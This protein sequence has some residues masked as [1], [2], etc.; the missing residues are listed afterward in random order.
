MGK[1]A[2]SKALFALMLVLLLAL[3][4]CSDESASEEADDNGSDE[5]TEDAEGT[6][7]DE[8]EEEE[9]EVDP[10][11]VVYSIDDFNHTKTNEGEAIDGGTLNF[12]LVSD[13]VFEGTLNW[14]FYQGAPDAEVIEWFDESLL[15]IDENYNYTNDGA[16]T[17]EADEDANT[18]T[19]TI[20][21]DV[22]WHDGEPVTAEDWAFSYEVIGDPEYTGIRYGADFTVIEGMEE[23]NSGDADE[24]SG[25]EII[26][27]KSMEIT[28]KQ[29][30]PS[31]LAG[32]AWPYAMPKH[33]F[34][35]IPVAE[36]EEAP[37]VRENPIGMG[38]FKV[39][40]IT[41][42][43]SVTYT[44]NEDYWRGE[45][46]L[47]GVTLQVVNP[48]VVVQSLET[49]EVD[50]VDSFPTDQYPENAEM[51]NI[52]YLGGVDNAYT[53]IG[54]KL[55]EWDDDAGE[56]VMDDSKKMADVDLRRAM[57]HAVDNDAVGEQFY[58]GLRWNAT[59]LIAPSH[60]D[61]HDDSIEAPTYDPDTANQILDEAGY[62]DVTDDGFRETPDGDELVINFASMSGGDTAE[63]I[64]QYY[65]QSWEDIGIN[66]QLLDGRLIEF[67]AFYDMVE[68]DDPEIDIY[69]G[70]WSVGSDVNP[71]G[72]Y[73]PNAMFNYS[74]YTSE[75][76]EALLEEG[77][78][79]DSF[80]IEHRQSVYSE[81]QELMV[82][83]VPVFPT[84]YRAELV[85]VNNRVHNFSIETGTDV[86]RSDIAVT[87]EET[88][89][90]E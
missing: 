75:E 68:E 18:I 74:R 23:Y 17:F 82:E 45:P 31:L 11:D 26:D 47:D 29:L 4:A 24:I 27:D 21:D 49:G 20:R 41:P 81:W 8:E 36:M 70:A 25:I 37:E 57:W 9:E 15:T 63:P 50:M 71:S 32:G 72:L 60:P 48:N 73:G 51:S 77:V 10:G 6:E 38:P 61:Y 62:E 67:N 33:V 52:E 1:T 19:F 13:T 85:P 30:N 56:V 40:T 12:G 78:S 46:N 7:D 16:A 64:A 90:A 80:D 14:N 2:F 22:N 54:F 39:D 53:Y 65:I 44:K 89:A 79:E 55:G 35:D 28:Y 5:G 3:A 69:Q 83:D 58:N 66:V 59:T 87:E 34:E 86:Y 42:G 43:E 88:P 84:V 76:N